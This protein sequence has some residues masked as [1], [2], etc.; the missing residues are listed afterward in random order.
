MKK[1][2]QKG[3]D[4]Q[5]LEDISEAKMIIRITPTWCSINVS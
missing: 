4:I 5:R 3:A 1:I 2:C